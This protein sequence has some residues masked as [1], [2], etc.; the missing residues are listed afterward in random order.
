MSKHWTELRDENV[1]NRFKLKPLNDKQDQYLFAIETSTITLGLG[2]AG[3]GKTYLACYLASQMLLGGR[4]DRIILTRPIIGC[5]SGIGFLP[6]DIWEK[7]SP[8]MAPMLDCFDE[9]LSPEKFAT[10]LEKDIIKLVPLELMRGFSVKNSVI[11]ADEMQNAS[12][13]QLHMLLTRFG[14][15]SRVIICG[16][17][18]QSDLD[19]Q[20][21]PLLD[22]ADRIFGHP[23]ISM[24]WFTREDVV[25]HPLIQ[26]IDERL[27]K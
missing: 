19:C 12:Y 23:D 6:G 27:S 17:V 15:N 21:N 4:I 22:V 5:G 1:Q 25:R 11:I 20:K 10:Y 7:T 14:A 13:T 2:T 8:Y 3:T 18:K 16:D 9:F 26:Y 24:V